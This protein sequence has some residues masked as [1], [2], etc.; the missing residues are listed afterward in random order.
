M[1]TLHVA[2][3][4]CDG[5]FGSLALLARDDVRGVPIGPVVLR[6]GR[7]VR[8]M[9]CFC[10]SQKL[11]QTRDVQVAESS[12]GKPRRD[13]LEQPAVAVRIA[14]RRIGSVGATVGIAAWYRWSSEGREVK[15]LT[16]VGAAADQL[17]ACR[18]DVGHNQIQILD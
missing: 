12:A 10:L 18:L 13:L 1:G 8:A 16:H 14:E 2:R 11:R 9:A 5:I 6:R 7:F 15:R 4:I 17:P 3:A